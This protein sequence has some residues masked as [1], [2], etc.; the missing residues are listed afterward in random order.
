MSE[1]QPMPLVLTKPEQDGEI[2]ML[3]I[4]MR[5]YPGEALKSWRDMAAE[6]ERLRQAAVLESARID[7][8]ID[9]RSQGNVESD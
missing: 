6:K 5:R 9:I 1:R 2:R 3:R 8:L 4:L 7:L